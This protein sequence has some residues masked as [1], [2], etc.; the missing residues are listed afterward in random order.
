MVDSRAN[1]LRPPE[2]GPGWTYRGKHPCAPLFWLWP[3][4]YSRLR[5]SDADT[6]AHEVTIT[7]NGTPAA[8]LIGMN[9]W[10]SL[11]DTLFWLSQP[12]ELRGRR[13]G[14]GEAGP[15]A[16]L[17]ADRA[18]EHR[19]AFGDLATSPRRVGK[20]LQRELAGLLG[21]R[22]GPY[23]IL[24][25]I[26]D[27]ANRVEM[28]RVDHRSDIY[29]S[30]WQETGRMPRKTAGTKQFPYPKATFAMRRTWVGRSAATV[31]RGGSVNE[32]CSATTIGLLRMAL[33]R[34]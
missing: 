20:P 5:L 9:E 23:R 32:C 15:A 26:D 19:F 24:D 17:A 33:S 7:K 1:T 2:S 25:S 4:L 11:Q 30:D 12:G 21:A 29:R 18:R 34:I 3:G 27:D 22:R 31:P 13:D 10:E 14:D 8:V 28:L 6:S 16:H